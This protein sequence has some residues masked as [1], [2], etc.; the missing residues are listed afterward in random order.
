[1]EFQVRWRYDLS[2]EGQSHSSPEATCAEQVK[3]FM[4]VLESLAIV[5]TA[6]AMPVVRVVRP[7]ARGQPVLM[8]GDN[9]SATTL[10]Y[11]RCEGTHGPRAACH[12]V[13]RGVGDERGLVF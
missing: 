2:V 6:C 8:R 9:V 7:A 5:V 3:G 1:M 11:Y 10:I 4:N 12:E 13:A